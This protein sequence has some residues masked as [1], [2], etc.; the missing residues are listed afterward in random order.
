MAVTLDTAL[1]QGNQAAGSN[2]AITTTSSVAVGGRVIVVAGHFVN[3]VTTR[4]C[5]G[6]GLTWA[7]DVYLRAT[8]L[9]ISVFSAAAPA[10]LASSTVLTVTYNNAGDSILG[11]ISLLGID[12]VSPVVASNT[13][14]AS[15][16]GWS[17]GTVAATSGNAL[18]GGAFVDSASVTLSTPTAPGVE[19]FDD[20]VGAQSETATGVYKLSV[21]G[22]DVIDGTWDA[23]AAWIAA[24]VCYKALPVGATL[25]WIGAAG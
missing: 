3:G 23:A 2:P 16:A 18:V 4:S 1:G 21:A 25:A 11:A 10:G 12:P 9:H 19:W 17:S 15:T 14:N 8:A 7:E 13:N 24:A 6:G 5:G 22:S 20:H